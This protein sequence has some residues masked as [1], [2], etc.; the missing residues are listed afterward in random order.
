MSNDLII[1]R[2]WW[3][4][5]Q[6]LGLALGVIGW[7]SMT[8]GC[9]PSKVHIHSSPQFDSSA[10]SSIAIIPFQSLQTP[11]GGYGQAGGDVSDPEEIRMQFRLPGADHS[12]LHLLGHTPLEAF[13]ATGTE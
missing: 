1:A 4:G 12:R 5:C 11:Q 9:V 3:Q 13:A 6:T 2:P 7:A 8:I 10:I